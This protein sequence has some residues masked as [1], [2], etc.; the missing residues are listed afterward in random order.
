MKRENFA[1]DDKMENLLY[2]R[3]LL[4]GLL[5]RIRIQFLFS[6][7]LVFALRKAIFGLAI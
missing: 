7:M 2:E 3:K 5:F 1:S 6:I 4:V